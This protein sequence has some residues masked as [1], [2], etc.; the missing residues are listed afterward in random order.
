MVLRI[1]SFLSLRDPGRPHAVN[2]GNPAAFN[3]LSNG[4]SKAT[5]A[6]GI[7]ASSSGIFTLTLEFQYEW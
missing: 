7:Q 6:S 5:L 2:R 1:L 4:K 3:V